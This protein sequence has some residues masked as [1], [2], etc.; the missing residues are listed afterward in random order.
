MIRENTGNFR[1]SKA[2]RPTWQVKIPGIS[3]VFLKIPYSTDQ[4]ISKCYQGIILQEQGFFMDNRGNR[5]KVLR[6]NQST[7]YARRAA[8]FGRGGWWIIP[9]QAP[10]ALDR[11]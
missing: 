10:S 9:L 5:I 7:T 4:G 8:M 11:R 3:T 6:P 1:D 2:G